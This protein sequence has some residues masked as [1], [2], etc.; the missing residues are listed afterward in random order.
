MKTCAALFFL[1]FFLSC[2]SH[3]LESRIKY[4]DHLAA[5]NS[6][7]KSVFSG[8]DFN[9]LTYTK[10]SSTN[11]DSV[12][13]YIEGDGLAWKSRHRISDNPTPINPL[14][15]KLAL[16]DPAPNVIY[17]ARP[18]QYLDLKSQ[19]KCQP[20]FWSEARFSKEVV[21]ATDNAI[22]QLVRQYHFKKINLFGYSGGGAI[23]VLVAAQRND[24]QLI[25]T[26]AANLNHQEFTKIHQ[27]TPM[28]ESLDAIDFADKVK[29]IEQFHFIGG[30]DSTV[31]G[32]IIISFVTKVNKLGGNAKFRVI[33][34]L[35]HNDE[36]W[37]EIWRDKM[38][39][40]S[41]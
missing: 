11:R 9:L 1:G 32:T 3:S 21:D 31:P 28:S 10:I 6:F 38:Q 35:T 23:A 24:V 33:S 30:H 8:T 15:L 29:N 39:N 14:A 2:C 4:A 19:K 27:V 13:I 25:G 40:S 12:D 41:K 18:C 5:T 22:S 36:K 17:I 20:K 37:P 34:D 7:R 16:V 26:V